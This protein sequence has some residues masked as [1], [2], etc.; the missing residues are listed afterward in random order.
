[1]NSTIFT[2]LAIRLPD[3]WHLWLNRKVFRLPHLE[4]PNIGFGPSLQNNSKIW[5]R[6]LFQIHKFAFFSIQSC[7]IIGVY[8]ALERYID[9]PQPIDSGPYIYNLSLDSVTKYGRFDPNNHIFLNK[10][11]EL[12]IKSSNRKIALKR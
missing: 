4:R 2:F 12:L 11:F 9:S 6:K 1:M 8:D 10:A 5:L 3:L 7:H